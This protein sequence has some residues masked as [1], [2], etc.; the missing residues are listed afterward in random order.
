MA[1]TRRLPPSFPR[2]R[3]RSGNGPKCVLY[4]CYHLNGSTDVGEK[5]YL[6]L[7][8]PPIRHLRGNENAI[9]RGQEQVLKVI[10]KLLRL[11]T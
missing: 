4:A 3:C 6:S 11:K 10:K 1:C 2:S 9:K 5:C 8:A 7:L